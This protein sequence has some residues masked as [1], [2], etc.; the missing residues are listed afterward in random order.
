MRTGF[1]M[2]SGSPSGLSVVPVQAARMAT[3]AAW[4]DVNEHQDEKETGGA[5]RLKTDNKGGGEDFG[6][7]VSGSEEREDGG[8]H[9]AGEVE[10]ADAVGLSDGAEAPGEG[11]EREEQ[12]EAREVGVARN[13]P[14]GGEGMFGGTDAHQIDP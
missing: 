5:E 8:G 12:G 4:R 1:V 3:T 13:P 11:E 7:Q 6:E 9:P 2:A 10:R 14:C